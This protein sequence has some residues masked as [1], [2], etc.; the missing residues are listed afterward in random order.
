MEKDKLRSHGVN[1]VE[2]EQDYSI[3]VEQ[4]RKEAEKIRPASLL[5]MRT[6]QHSF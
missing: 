2:Y 4:G 6:P 3:A 1:V 5:M